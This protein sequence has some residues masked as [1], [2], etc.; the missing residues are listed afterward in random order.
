MKVE[1]IDL[2]A[3]IE[4]KKDILK[5]INKVLTKNDNFNDEV[6]KFEKSICSYT[7]AK[8]CL[9]LNQVLML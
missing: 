5:L 9:G 3:D 6:K 4:K 8:Y 1:L 2:R 7:G